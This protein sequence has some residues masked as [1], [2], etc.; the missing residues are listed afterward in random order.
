MR[1]GRSGR[2]LV[3][4]RKHAVGLRAWH[5]KRGA[6]EIGLKA[7]VVGIAEPLWAVLEGSL[8]RS[9]RCR[10]VRYMG[11]ATAKEESL[12]LL[13]RLWRMPGGR[14]ALGQPPLV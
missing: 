1:N 4:R 11:T 7:G 13:V 2:L 8:E 12:L 9:P 10:L 14:A 3:H 6:P 5:Q